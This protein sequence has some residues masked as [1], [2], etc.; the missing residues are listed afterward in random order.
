MAATAPT[1]LLALTNARV[2][3]P[4]ITFDDL[5]T[6]HGIPLNEV[7]QAL[8]KATTTPLLPCFPEWSRRKATLMKTRSGLLT[9]L[10]YI[11]HDRGARGAH[12]ALH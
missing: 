8:S 10:L 2:H 1:I 7:D 3:S 5:M 11:P 4:L 6:G 12:L 9:I